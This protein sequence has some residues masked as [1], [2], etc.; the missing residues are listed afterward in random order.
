M[1]G[2]F[3]VFEGGEGSGKSSMLKYVAD[4]LRAEGR[5]VVATREP[6]GSPYAELIRSVILHDSGKHADAETM[7][8]L[9]WAA[10]RDHMRNTVIPA[11]ERGDIVMSDRFDGS[12]FTYQIHGQQHPQLEPH[13]WHMRKRIVEPHTPRAYLFFDVDP[14]IGLARAKLRAGGTTHFDERESD[15]HERI[16]AGYKQFFSSDDPRIPHIV[17]DASLTLEVVQELTLQAVRK[18]IA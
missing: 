17:L 16:R 6:G 2:T 3:I 11:L 5:T 1:Y 14:T 4:A 13:F 9:F 15:F 12:S 7:A 18:L 8:G 10:R